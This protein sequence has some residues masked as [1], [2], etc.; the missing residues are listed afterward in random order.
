MLRSQQGRVSVGQA[1]QELDHLV[2]VIQV[3]L[4]QVLLGLFHELTQL[5]HEGVRLA[6]DGALG[7]RARHLQ[8]AVDA[9]RRHILDVDREVLRRRATR[10]AGVQRLGDGGHVADALRGRGHDAVEGLVVHLRRLFLAGLAR[11][12]LGGLPVA[13]RL[14][15]RFAF[16]RGEV[17]QF[18]RQL[19]P[20]RRLAH[21]QRD[22][23]LRPER[24]VAARRGAAEFHHL[25]HRLGAQLG[26]LLH[27]M[28]LVVFLDVH[29]FPF[30]GLSHGQ[31]AL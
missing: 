29:D 2:V 3:G 31:T 20:L 26:E 6:A 21:A 14:D 18:V 13:P 4:G 9:Q 15:G 25:V 24:T 1:V 8:Q 11:L 19:G 27:R 10:H 16:F 28:H 12:D 23:L 5:H 22:G 7:E 30:H 17:P